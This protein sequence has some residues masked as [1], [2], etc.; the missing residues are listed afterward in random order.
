MQ[1]VTWRLRVPMGWNIAD[2]TRWLWVLAIVR[3]SEQDKCCSRGRLVIRVSSLIPSFP[4]GLCI[5][6]GLLWGAYS[7]L[8]IRWRTLIH[9]S[10]GLFIYFNLTYLAI[11]SLSPTLTFLCNSFSSFLLLSL[12]LSISVFIISTRSFFSSTS[13]VLLTRRECV[14]F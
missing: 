13:S 1:N 3:I 7:N 14:P 8:W 5:P 6:V 4:L 12:F 10:Y 9:S 11:P 2:E